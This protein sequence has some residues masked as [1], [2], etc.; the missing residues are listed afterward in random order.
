MTSM[1][2]P[3]PAMQSMYAAGTSTYAAAP[4]MTSMYMPANQT[5][6]AVAAPTVVETVAAPTVAATTKVPSIVPAPTVVAAPVVA[7][8]A[9]GMP[10]PQKLT[11]GMPEPALLEKEKVAYSQALE[12]Q[13][14][15]QTDAVL[16]E[17]NIK[18]KMLEAQATKDRAQ[19]ELQLNEKLKMDCLMVD[20]QASQQVNGL[21]EAAITQ[22]T[23]REEQA[24][25]MTADYNKKKCLEDFAFKSWDLQKQWFEK[26]T[27]FQKQYEAVAKKGAGAISTSVPQVAAPMTQIVQQVTAAP[28]VVEYA[29]T[30]GTATI[31]APT[32]VG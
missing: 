30:I 25:R 3:I 26:E 18:K 8:P 6:A 28:A 21:R 4:V 19:F 23:S 17:A 10:Q 20:Q 31:A 7:A 27:A 16:E 5:V 12:A 2:A 22:Q 9:F 13:L 11:A 14:K 1:V 24:A 29:T 32:I 15:K